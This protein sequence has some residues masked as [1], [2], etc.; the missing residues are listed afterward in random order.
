MNATNNCPQP[1]KVT[2]EITDDDRTR[3]HDVIS[4]DLADWQVEQVVTPSKIYPRQEKLLALHWHP[5][6][7]PMDL[8]TRRVNAM[9]P[10]VTDKMMIPTQHNILM[11]YGDYTGV[12]V[13]CYASG[14]N[15]KVQL[16]LHFEN[17][18]VREADVLK[19][20]LAHTFKYRSSQL[21]EY[22]D[23][24]TKPD[25]EKVGLAARSTGA[26][27]E[28]VEMVRVYVTKIQTML[29]EEWSDVPKE[30][31]KNKLLKNY[32]DAMRPIYGDNTINRVQ[33]YLKAIKQL[34]KSNFSLKY[35]YRATE[36]IEEAR[37]L[38]GCVVIPHPE[39]FWPILLA[40]YDVDG[41][42]VWNPQSQRYTDFLISVVDQQ[43]TARPSGSRKRLI[44]MGD[45]CHMSEK[46][47]RPETQ[48]P[49]KAAREIGLQPAWDDLNIRKKL[50]IAGIDR[51]S[52]ITE[53]RE[54]LAG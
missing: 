44:F 20:M 34:V 24:I 21:F 53:Y 22:M 50:I 3:F 52:V 2:P 29:D 38:G 7:V 23:A 42:E 25:E 40:K 54:R 28:L 35:F 33:A 14:F 16:L 10:N 5:E 1:I 6:F 26:D 45:D 15:Q 37:S 11:S 13:D 32:F 18:R 31:I 39:E 4:T 41:I 36:V 43:N 47:K 17:E 49:V 12:E 46:T 9:F 27:D 48:D 19:S 30:S 51:Q 8:I